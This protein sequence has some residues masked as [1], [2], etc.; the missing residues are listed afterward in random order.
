MAF[1]FDDG[2]V[3]RKMKIQPTQASMD[4]VPALIA[5]VD[6][7]PRKEYLIELMNIALNETQSDDTRTRAVLLFNLERTGK[8]E[9]WKAKYEEEHGEAEVRVNTGDE[10]SSSELFV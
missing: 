2:E 5:F 3:L 6:A 8:I 1:R 7:S 4:D 9:E 10:G